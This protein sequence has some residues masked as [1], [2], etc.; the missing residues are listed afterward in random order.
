MN[1]TVSKAKA[2][3]LYWLGRYVERVFISLNAVKK[4]ID[5]DIDGS[6]DAYK[7][8]CQR[9]CIPDS[10]NGAKDFAVKYLYDKTNPY[11]VYSMLVRAFDNGI[12]LRDDITSESL[13]YIHL[14]LDVME[15]CSLTNAGISLLQPV[16]DYMLSFWGS[17]DETVVEI[18][19]MN[20]LRLGRRLESLDLNVRLLANWDKINEILK[21]GVLTNARMLTSVTDM[22]K[23]ERLRTLIEHRSG[24]NN[25][26]DTA[27]ILDCINTLF[28][29]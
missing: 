10:Y 1:T 17:I 14:A 13:S 18:L 6:E 2:D 9:V 11:S 29:A 21:G 26:S 24:K 3:R 25:G 7:V 5:Y 28:N 8:Y 4:Y 15:K 16:C 19:K 20:I 12:E 22:L 27:E 23:T